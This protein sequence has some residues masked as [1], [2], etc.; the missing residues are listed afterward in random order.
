MH[1]ILI[2]LNNSNEMVRDRRAKQFLYKMTMCKYFFRDLL[3]TLESSHF[4]SQQTYLSVLEKSV[5]LLQSNPQ[6]GNKEL[7]T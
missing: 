2:E 1:S 3:D 6:W 5:T 4:A 7:D